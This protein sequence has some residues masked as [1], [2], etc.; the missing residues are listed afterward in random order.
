MISS[1]KYLPVHLVALKM[2]GRKVLLSRTATDTVKVFLI[3]FT[4]KESICKDNIQ[5]K[6]VIKGAKYFPVHLTALV[7]TVRKRCQ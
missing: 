5:S 7:L 4:N 1:P 6:T 3:D 2:T